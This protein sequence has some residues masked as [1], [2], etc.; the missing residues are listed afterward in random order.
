MAITAMHVANTILSRAFEEN[1]PITPMKLQKLIYIIYKVYYKEI[2]KKIFTEPFSAWKRGPVVPT[3]YSEFK[4][5]RGN[6]IE[7]FSYLNDGRT[8]TAIDLDTSS[9]F[10]KVFNEVWREYA[11][12]S[13]YDLSEM[14]HVSDGAWDKAIKNESYILRDEDI[15]SE[16]NY[17]NKSC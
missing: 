8:Y 15:E 12:E 1:V 5:Y 11:H 13:A 6:P 10:R 3:V 16:S 7:D 9:D 14:T 17:A 2:G 4:N